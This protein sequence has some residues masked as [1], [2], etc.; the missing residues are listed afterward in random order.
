M[1]NRPDVDRIERDL[2]ERSPAL[3]GGSIGTFA[4]LF[5]QLARA[6]AA[7]RRSRPRRNAL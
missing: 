5:E 2:L 1:Q 7:A 4:D 3:L 6:D